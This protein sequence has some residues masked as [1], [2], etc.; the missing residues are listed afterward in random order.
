MPWDYPVDEILDYEERGRRQIADVEALAAELLDQPTV[1]DAML[2]GLSR[3]SHRM[4]GVFGRALGARASNPLDLFE[5]IAIA[6]KSAPQDD[7][8]FGLLGGFLGSLA[9]R[10]PDRV[11]SFK[12]EAATSRVFGPTLPFVCSC[13]GLVDSDIGLAIRAMN[14]GV[15][16][17]ATLNAWAYGRALV[18]LTPLAIAPLFDKLFAGESEALSLGLILLGMY[19]HGDRGRLNSFRPQ[20]RLVA[21]NAGKRLSNP[22]FQMADHQFKEIMEWILAKGRSDSDASAIALSMA[23]QI[24]DASDNVSDGLI[25]PL[26]PR[27]LHDFPEVTW[28]II[29][30]A[31]VRDR[32]EAWR[33]EIVLAGDFGFQGK[34]PV[35]LDLPEDSLFAWLHA[36]PDVAPAFAA[37]MLPVLTSR[38]PNDNSRTI[39]PCMRRLLNEFGQRDDVLK[40]LTHNMHA[41]GWMG[42]EATYFALY[43]RPLQELKS[44]PIGAVRRWAQATNTRLREMIK[45]IHNEEDERNANWEL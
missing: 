35:I 12:E 38:D 25:K 34:R 36:H 6:Y 27:L 22:Q 2:P 37:G 15:L 21:T 40:A 16:P 32:K 5:R 14:A 30:E 8:N 4:V 7:A 33:M 31:I 29:G 3:G 43:E 42:S 13:I 20:L 11:A 18:D 44:H 28:P 9:H 10:H 24:A 17:I 19:V 23:T 41:F 1:L 45:S 26:L 39:H